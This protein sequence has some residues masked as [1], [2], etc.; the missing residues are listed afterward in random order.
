MFGNCYMGGNKAGGRSSEGRLIEIMGSE[1]RGP[2]LFDNTD[3]WVAGV[4]IMG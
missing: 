2:Q 4:D 3:R 1:E